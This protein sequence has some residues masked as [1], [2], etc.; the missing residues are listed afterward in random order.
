MAIGFSA[1]PQASHVAASARGAT[2][3]ASADPSRFGEIS[4]ATIVQP[5]HY[6]RDRSY[7][8][9]GKFKDRVAGLIG[10]LNVA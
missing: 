9:K 4:S 7:S 5:S 10:V 8:G 1:E 6:P 2:S 3:H